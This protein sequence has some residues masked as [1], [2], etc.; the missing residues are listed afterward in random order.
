MK[1]LYRA[2]PVY[3]K[4]LQKV[5]SGKNIILVEPD[6][7]IL[8]AYPNGLDVD[9]P[10]LYTLIDRMNYAPEGY[11]DRYRPYGHGYVLAMQLLEDLN[12]K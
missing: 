3:Q 8:E 12:K 6:G 10:L 1:H 7:P 11:P 9:L 2:H 5:K 4:L